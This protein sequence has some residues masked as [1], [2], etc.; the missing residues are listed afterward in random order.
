LRHPI[1][2]IDLAEKIATPL[3]LI[4][5]IVAVFNGE[6]TLEQCILSVEN[7]TY[8]HKQ[9]IVIDGGS[10]DGTV[11]LLQKNAHHIDYWISE[12][13]SGVYSAWNKGLV[14][15]AGEWICFLGADDYFF[16]T[17]TLEKLVKSL[18][19]VP[20]VINIAY[21]QVMVVNKKGEPLFSVGEPWD[22]SSSLFKAGK[23]L[24]HQGVM[25]RN[26]LFMHQGFFD[27]SFKIGGDYE[28]MLRELIQA[29]AFYIP[30]VISA[31]MRQGGL[32]SNPSSSA[33]A[34]WDI[35]RAQVMHGLNCPSIFWLWGMAKIYIRSLLWICLGKAGAKK[36]FEFKRKRLGSLK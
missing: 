26:T 22:K 10:E 7:Q 4:T 1:F 14:H 2:N 12:K 25:H 32:S 34:M 16:E 23:C 19:V 6:A 27:E 15:A 33:Q 24:P 21:S 9:L 5:I 8:A 29:D 11:S 28:L 13:D 3:P 17:S 18:Q 36:I 35:R 20:S 30:R 31:A